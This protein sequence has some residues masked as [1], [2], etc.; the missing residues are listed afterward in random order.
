MPYLFSGGG[1]GGAVDWRAKCKQEQKQPEAISEGGSLLKPHVCVLQFSSFF[2]F[3]TVWK[4][5]KK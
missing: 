4:T 3:T 1:W 2:M 5:N